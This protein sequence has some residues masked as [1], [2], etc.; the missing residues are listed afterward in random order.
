MLKRIALMK[1]GQIPDEDK[2][3]FRE[4]SSALAN[5]WSSLLGGSNESPAPASGAAAAK[6]DDAA[7]A[8]AKA[9]DAEPKAEG[10]A[11]ADEPAP[12]G[13][14]ADEDKKDC[15]LYTSPSPRDS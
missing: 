11:K 3:S 6:A 9:D 5:K 8:P 4:R 2:Y 15:L 10:D 1:D 13:A 12:A 14:P 7:A